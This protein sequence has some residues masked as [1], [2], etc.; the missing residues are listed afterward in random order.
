MRATSIVSSV[1]LNN[2]E[3]ANVD[4]IKEVESSK[5]C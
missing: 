4:A 2:Y 5:G 1:P 3:R